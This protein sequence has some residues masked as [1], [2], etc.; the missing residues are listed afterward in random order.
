MLS[1]LRI[2]NIAV[3]ESADIEFDGKLNVLTGE[4]GAGKSIVIDSLCALLG[5]RTSRDLIRTGFERAEVSGVFYSYG[6][7]A[8]SFLM[9]NGIEADE[10]LMLQRIMNQDGRNVCRVDGKPVT[11]AFLR[12][13]GAM[14]VN[15]HGQHDNQALLQDE[16]HIGFLD[17]FGAID[18]TK[19]QS[20]YRHYLSICKELEGLNLAEDEKKSR[21]DV[22]SR[23]L[24]EL[25]TLAPE[26]GEQEALTSRRKLL[27]NAEKIYSALNEAYS[28][29]YGDEDTTG[30]CD[31][32]EAAA[33]AVDL[34]SRHSEELSE[35]G[36]RL[37]EARYSLRDC[38]AELRTIRDDMEDTENE[39]EQTEARLE[40]LHR[41]SKRLNLTID[42]IIDRWD[43]W[44][45]ELEKLMS[46]ERS[47][48]ELEENRD[49]AYEDVVNKAGELT[50]LRSN[51]ANILCER[52]IAELSELDMQ[53]VSFSVELTERE[54]GPTGVDNVR[55]LISTNPGEP[56]KPLSRVASGGEMARIMLAL[57]NLLSEGDECT[58]L[59]FDEVDQ[60]VSGRAAQRVAQKLSQVSQHKQVLCVT[61]LPQISAMA[62]THF[63][64]EKVISGE[65]T[66]T[67]VDKLS[68]DGRKE[69]IA[70]LISG[71][72]ITETTRKSAKELL[73]QAESYKNK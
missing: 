45:L 22:L 40:E 73:I 50:K 35:I 53:K 23:R 1:L 30:A 48:S 36:A 66:I 29:L 61:H 46:S 19:Y 52:M 26:R 32:A 11:V 10:E 17:S 56:L 13:L 54:P 24:E 71:T 70:R 9:E 65:R 72:D 55:F 67:K 38:A 33:D 25:E 51:S 57:K 27:R 68:D 6:S 14:L 62:D 7:A 8:A 58:T 42:E 34:V 69:E 64:I 28:A 12:E 5:Q 39:L 3:I 16:K 18:L 43:S 15:I 41:L 63:H 4:T 59:V 2:E 37:S 21:I 47:I 60:G 44:A 31:L 20:L 49:K